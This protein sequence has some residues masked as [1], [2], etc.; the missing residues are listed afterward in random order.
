MHI[1]VY[2]HKAQYYETDAMGIVH[3]SNYF[4]WFEEART[5][6]LEQTGYSYKRLEEE[7]IISPVLAIDAQYKSSVRYGDTVFI[8]V[9]ITKFNGVKLF[10]AYEITDALTGELRTTGNSEHCLLHS[11]SS[12]VRLKKENQG[13][14]ELL[15]SLVEMG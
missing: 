14:Y 11:D 6:F 5:D 4:R 7:D 2:K 1:T 12:F 13:L 8:Q 15:L 3:H 9:K 10:F